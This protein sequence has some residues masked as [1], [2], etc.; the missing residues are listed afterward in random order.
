MTQADVVWRIPSDY[1]YMYLASLSD[2]WKVISPVLHLAYFKI[3]EKLYSRKKDTP[4]NHKIAKF[5]THENFRLYGI[6]IMATITKGPTDN[7]SFLTRV[8][9]V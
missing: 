1:D 4:F 6:N 2:P 5:D 8:T 7:H 3:C 9:W